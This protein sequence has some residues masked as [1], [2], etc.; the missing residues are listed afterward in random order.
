LPVSNHAA[1]IAY[2]IVVALGRLADSLGN[3]FAVGK[4]V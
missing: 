4:I 1:A 2:E 3:V